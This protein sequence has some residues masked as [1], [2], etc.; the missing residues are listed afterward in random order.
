MKSNLEQAYCGAFSYFFHTGAIFFNFCKKM[1]K[2][3]NRPC[4]LPYEEVMEAIIKTVNSV[5]N[6]MRIWRIEGKTL[7]FLMGRT[8]G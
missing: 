3:E 2:N 8:E 4:P 1:Q 7:R 6:N 5:Q